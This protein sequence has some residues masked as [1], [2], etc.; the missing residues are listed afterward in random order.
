MESALDGFMQAS[1]SVLLLDFPDSGFLRGGLESLLKNE[2]FM[3]LAI[4]LYCYN[5]WFPLVF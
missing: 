1:W 5:I 3:F 2:V 4:F